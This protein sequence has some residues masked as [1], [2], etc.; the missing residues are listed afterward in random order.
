[1]K[2]KNF[3]PDAISVKFLRQLQ[4]ALPEKRKMIVFVARNEQQVLGRLLVARYGDT[5]MT[6]VIGL[7]A[8]GQN[9]HIN[10]FLYWEAVKRMKKLGYRWF[11]LGGAHP[12]NTP[13]GILHFK[14]GFG[15]NL[16]QL[17]NEIEAYPTIL[18]YKL[19]NII[20]SKKR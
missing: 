20:I 4:E 19:L 14:Q 18:L 2:E 16:Y 10:H 17:A 9:W 12:D 15:G 1:M 8:A 13:H 7:N 3:A 6:Y 5:A 11:D